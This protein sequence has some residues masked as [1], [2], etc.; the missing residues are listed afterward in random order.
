M[1]MSSRKNLNQIENEKQQ[2]LRHKK[3]LIKTIDNNVNNSV[4]YNESIKG[5][6]FKLEVFSLNGIKNRIKLNQSSNSLYIKFYVSFYN[7]ILEFIGNTCISKLISVTTKNDYLEFDPKEAVTFYF[8]KSDLN[9]GMKIVVEIVLYEINIKD[10]IVSYSSEGWGW[11]N[12]KT[13]VKD[14]SFFNIFLGSP[15][16]LISNYDSIKLNGA[17]VSFRLLRQKEIDKFNFLLPCFIS[18]TGSENKG[19]VINNEILPGTT[20]II[21]GIEMNYLPNII[22]E[23]LKLKQLCEFYIKN[24][25]LEITPDLELQIIQYARLYFKSKSYNSIENIFIKERKLRIGVHNTWKYINT[26]GSNNVISLSQKD[27]YLISKNILH[28]DNY[29]E[30]MRDF[31]GIIFELI[32]VID[33]SNSSTNSNSSIS[34]SIGEGIYN[35]E[36]ISNDNKFSSIL[37]YTNTSTISGEDMLNITINKQMKLRFIVTKNKEMYSKSYKEEEI[38]RLKNEIENL[39]KSLIGK[40][41]SQLLENKI[42]YLENKL[43]KNQKYLKAVYDI[44][45]KYNFT[46]SS[47]TLPIPL[48]EIQNPII[49]SMTIN[50]ENQIINNNNVSVSV[51][52]NTQFRISTTQIQE[53][54]QAYIENKLNINTLNQIKFLEKTEEKGNSIS[55]INLKS[56]RDE[57]IIDNTKII[58]NTKEIY[59][60]EETNIMNNQ[61]K[62]ESNP[63]LKSTLNN[64]HNEIESF[65]HEKYSF[66]KNQSYEKEVNH[67]NNQSNQINSNDSLINK[68]LN[69]LTKEEL[70]QIIL[71]KDLEES[72]KV[73]YQV[74]T[75]NNTD[76]IHFNR[77]NYYGYD[78]KDMKDISKKDKSELIGKGVLLDEDINNENLLQYSLET[79]MKEDKKGVN[80]NI[81]FMAIKPSK[82]YLYMINEDIL[83]KLV[84]T[85]SFWDFQEYQSDISIINKPENKLFSS[86]IPFVLSKEEYYDDKNIKLK[87]NYDP[88]NDIYIDYKEY[89]CYLLNKHLF[90]QI[91]DSE[92]L[93]NF[94]YVKIP[95]R[96]FLR[97]GKEIKNFQKE[98]YLYDSISHINK[99]S[100]ILSI[101]VAGFN[102][103]FTYNQM[104]FK[105]IYSNLLLSS[106]I[107]NKKKV[108]IRALDIDTLTIK[109]KEV[110]GME[111]INKNSSAIENLKDK[112]RENEILNKPIK[113]NVDLD[114]QKKLRVLKY[115][116]LVNKSNKFDIRINENLNKIEK[117]RL[118]ELKE[119]QEKEDKYFETLNK[120]NKIK[121]LKKERLIK[122]VIEENNKNQLSISLIAGKAHYFNYVIKNESDIEENFHLVISSNTNINTNNYNMSMTINEETVSIIKDPHI[123]RHITLTERNYLLAPIN[124]DY[125]CISE[126]NFFILKPN[127]KIPLLIKL[128]S[129]DNL[130][131][132]KSFTIWIYKGKEVM[133]YLS[134]TIVKVINIIDHKFDFNI[135]DNRNSNITIPNPF[136]KKPIFH[137]QQKE[138]VIENSH[139]KNNIDISQCIVDYQITSN[140]AYTLQLDSSSNN[141]LIKVKPGEVN[142]N[143][144]IKFYLFLYKDQYRI[145]NILNWEVTIN[146]L[147]TIDV[148]I[149]LGMKVNQKFLVDTNERRTVRLFTN[150]NDVIFF[151]D[152]FSVPLILIPDI[153]NEMKFIIYPKKKEITNDTLIN[154]VD[155][156]NKVIIKTIL[157]RVIPENPIF[158][159]VVRIDCNVGS[160]THFKYEYTSKLSKWAILKFSSNNEDFLRVIDSSLNFNPKETK[161]ISMVVPE[162]SQRGIAEEVILFISDAEEVYSETVLFKF[163]FK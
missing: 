8:F 57:K 116:N 29:I 88:S 141:Y 121:E 92:R 78:T 56:E 147:E 70:V 30:E 96:D 140:S 132:N 85:F 122:Q 54:S 114:T 162:Q 102:C 37:L 81:H 66:Q 9:G 5:E 112:G 163:H 19:K 60:K 107:S 31:C 160:P 153:S 82:E 129:Y 118:Y 79:E 119:K 14:K 97:N 52:Q 23:E 131:N 150:N 105:Q 11:I 44:D 27:I 67:T 3:S 157:I 38:S 106:G 117:E 120:A 134:I 77:D 25:E 136:E 71:Y 161:H 154:V 2:E 138:K 62:S 51:N 41:N 104:K 4:I 158:T 149:Q 28:M 90:I 110:I 100:I 155:I 26:N 151:N 34:L 12:M 109:E 50:N 58:N 24:I 35:P 64:N 45:D 83:K 32:Y 142:D 156:Y 127:E 95:L 43:C 124:N 55:N 89:I 123:W 6:G 125:D 128:L 73:K 15:R 20:S 49:P 68:S 48:P 135:P 40:S 145:N 75:T 80:Y 39:K 7:D 137:N 146:L 113:L 63:Y 84:F 16:N 1:I 59:D 143:K 148:N 133:E 61:F 91:F 87:L 69:T 33:I 139:L 159:H 99:G 21:P 101:S 22:N 72:K 47:K 98:Y 10:E 76:Q 93:F 103:S 126:N 13:E 42:S 65:P 144:K 18:I 36:Y 46:I 94:G 130:I 111:I 53:S 17:S 86:A 115:S 74:N 152:K 108:S